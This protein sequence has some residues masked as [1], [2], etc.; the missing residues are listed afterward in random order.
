MSDQALT[1]GDS[2]RRA[3]PSHVPLPPD[4]KLTPGVWL[5]PAGAGKTREQTRD[6][7]RWVD[8]DSVV[9]DAIGWPITSAWK[10]SDD[11]LASYVNVANWA[12]LYRY[13]VLHPDAAVM[14]NGT[15][16]MVASELYGSNALRGVLL[17][18]LLDVARNLVTHHST[19]TS[20]FEAAISNIPVDYLALISMARCYNVPV[21]SGPTVSALFTAP[22]PTSISP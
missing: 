22:K 8:G 15:I 3:L 10:T 2:L 11:E 13:C 1:L 12:A 20:S 16:P 19:R 14:F 5:A 21:Y 6:Q 7:P 18:D 17:P 9:Y 4:F